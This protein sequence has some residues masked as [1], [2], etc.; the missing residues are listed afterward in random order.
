MPLFGDDQEIP[1]MTQF[2]VETPYVKNMPYAF[3]IYFTIG[4]SPE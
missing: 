2:H 3:I 4:L 1:E